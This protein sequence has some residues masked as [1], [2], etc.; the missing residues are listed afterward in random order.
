MNIILYIS[1]KVNYKL[2]YKLNFM[3]AYC[4]GH[5]SCNSGPFPYKIGL[6]YAYLQGLYCSYFNQL[7]LVFFSS[8][9]LVFYFRKWELQLPVAKNW[10]QSIFYQF[11]LVA[12][13]GP[14]NTRA[15]TPQHRLKTCISSLVFFLLTLHITGQDLRHI[16]ISSPRAQTFLHMMAATP[17]EKV[18]KYI[19]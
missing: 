17:L 1:K 10:L 8:V 19:Y 6:K 15:A 9:L 16:H 12:A 18:F 2:S 11:F 3:A 5:S 14:R 7:Q 13:T 4:F